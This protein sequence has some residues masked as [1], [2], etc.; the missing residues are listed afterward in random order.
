MPGDQLGLCGRTGNWD[1]AHAH[2]EMTFE[3]PVQGWYQWPYGWSRD[4]VIAS[5]WNPHD[6]WPVAK[7]LVVKELSGGGVPPPEVVKVLSDW[8][9]ANWIMPDLWQWAGVEYNPDAGTTGAWIA[10]LRNG[11]YRGRP[12]TAERPFGTG[13]STGVWMEF[14]YGVL[15]Y[16]L[17]D[18]E[19]SWT[20]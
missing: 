6:W 3:A 8:E 1:C 19:A 20:G 12:R 14:D 10:E 7:E 18:G 2:T 4:K 15:T 9:L 13:D 16:R 11:R 5:Y 17:A